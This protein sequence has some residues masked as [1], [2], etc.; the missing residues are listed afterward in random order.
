MFEKN[1][2][3]IISWGEA[4]SAFNDSAR[5]RDGL[6]HELQENMRAAFA[7][8]AWNNRHGVLGTSQLTGALGELRGDQAVEDTRSVSVTDVV[9]WNRIRILAIYTTPSRRPSTEYHS[10][11]SACPRERLSPTSTWRTCTWTQGFQQTPA[12]LQLVSHVESQMK[13]HAH[14]SAGEGVT[15]LTSTGF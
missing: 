10:W 5:S 12:C 11:A 1:E 4:Y 6:C 3:K 2:S 13:N 14:F 7:K 15:H 8:L 9:H